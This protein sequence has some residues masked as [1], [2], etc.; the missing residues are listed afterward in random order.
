M[1]ASSFA[2]A[3]IKVGA[4][5]IDKIVLVFASP[6]S[7]MS[8]LSLLSALVIA[9]VFTVRK[10]WL[11]KRRVP[12]KVLRRALF[13]HALFTSPSSRAD[14][15]FLLLNT[16]CTTLLF[17]W[18]MVSMNF[19]SNGVIGGLTSAFG[20]MPSAGLSLFWS[21]VIITV[22]IYLAY[23]LGYW[24]DHYTSHKIPFF[25]EFH[26][27]HHAAEILSPLT[28]A[29]LHPI[30]GIKFANILALF[31]GTAEGIA[32]YLMGDGP[33]EFKL[34]GQNAIFLGFM[35]ALVH[36][37]HTHLW[38]AIT[39]FW[40]HV[41]NSPAHHQ[42][43]HSTNPIHFNKNL[44]STLS[45]WDWLFGTLHMPGKKREKLTFGVEGSAADVHTLTGSLLHPVRDAGLVLWRALP[46]Q[47]TVDP[48]A[49]TEAL[50]QSRQLS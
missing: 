39:G 28:N 15:W 4:N 30:D 42:I 32:R 31:M 14:L 49:P 44:G 21:S 46:T 27:V 36:L 43:H 40:G 23:D 33:Q 26:K 24:F 45:V 35:Y 50:R 19:F 41:V 10:R 7:S 18:A 13:P 48:A 37:Q 16:G 38:I 5:L 17:G 22:A 6:G 1:D 8:L 12:L 20:V 34:F 2:D 3:I 25:W 29:R 11:T 47:T 9:A